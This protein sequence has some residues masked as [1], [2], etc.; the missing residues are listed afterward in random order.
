MSDYDNIG[1]LSVDCRVLKS[2]DQQAEP[3]KPN[4][5]R[6][7]HRSNEATITT[8]ESILDGAPENCAPQPKKPTR[9]RVNMHPSYRPHTT[10]EKNNRNEIAI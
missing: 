4:N 7:R 1:F 8:V 3:L 9:S 5:S 10:N 2:V 6:K